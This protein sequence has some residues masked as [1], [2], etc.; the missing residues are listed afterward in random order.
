MI[1]VKIKRSAR[2]ALIWII[3]RRVCFHA[4]SSCRHVG[5][6]AEAFVSLLADL[7]GGGH[8]F[9]WTSAMIP[10]C[11]FCLVYMCWGLNPRP[12]R[13]TIYLGPLIFWDMI[14]QNADFPSWVWAYDPPASVFENSVITDVYSMPDSYSSC[15]L[16]ARSTSAR[17]INFPV[18][19]NLSVLFL[20]KYFY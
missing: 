19:Q 11:L 12:S 16:P 7:V 5:C 18:A 1:S 9:Q 14:S 20:I 15:I 3:W 13:W 8:S 10:L 4:N 2:W 6:R 17:S